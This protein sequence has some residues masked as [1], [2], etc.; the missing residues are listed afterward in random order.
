MQKS[1][2]LVSHPRPVSVGC[3]RHTGIIL[4]G[5]FG[6]GADWQEGCLDFNIQIG[7]LFCKYWWP[8]FPSRFLQTDNWMW[9]ENSILG[10]H[11]AQ[12]IY[13]TIFIISTYSL[14]ADFIQ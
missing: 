1:I 4:A 10:Q 2:Q 9:K 7:R 6:L 5:T 13:P 12:S 3:S 11:N 8:S 14:H